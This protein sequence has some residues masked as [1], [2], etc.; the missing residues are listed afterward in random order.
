MPV[1]HHRELFAW[2]TADGFKR[3]VHRLVTE[4]PAARSNFRYRDQILDASSDVDKDIVEGFRRKAPLEFAKFLDYA[5]ASLGEAEERLQDGILR[6][7]FS[8]TDCSQAIRYAK[9]CLTASVRLKASQL[10]YAAQLRAQKRATKRRRRP[11]T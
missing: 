11:R 9:R 4:S 1:R 7:Y 2:Q 3:E 5:L 8:E 6:G 10:R